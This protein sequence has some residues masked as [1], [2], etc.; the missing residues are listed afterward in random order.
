[1][2]RH[3]LQHRNAATAPPRTSFP[4]QKFP[5][6]RWPFEVREL[7][8]LAIFSACHLCELGVWMPHGGISVAGNP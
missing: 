2:S 3:T 7:P 6:M 5:A 1:M 8:R 4:V